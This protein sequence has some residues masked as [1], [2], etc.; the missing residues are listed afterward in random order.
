[1]NTEN[2]FPR[3][4]GILMHPTSLPGRFGVGDFGEEAYR[5]I[6]FL[7]DA[8][9]KLW[10]V[11]PL[12]PTGYGDSP[13]QS[14]SASAGNP[15]LISIERLIAS[16]EL[17]EGDL[18]EVPVFDED[19]VDFGAVIKFKE[20][21]LRK[22]A[23]R[24][25]RSDRRDEFDEF[26]RENAKWLDEFALFMALKEAHDLVAWSQ[27]PASLA[28]RDARALADWSRKLSQE[29]ETIKYWQFVF[30]RQWHELRE[31]GRQKGIRVIGD[32]PIYVAHDSANVWANRELF[33]L[34]ER[35]NP[36]KVAGVPPDYFSETGQLW[37]NPI[38]N[39]PLMKE[40]GYAWWVERLR[41][42]LRLYDYVRIDHF[43][44]FEAY[45]EVAASEKTAMNGRWVKGP[46][47]EL[48]EVLQRELGDLPII[49]ENLGVITPEVEEIRHRFRMP[50]MAIL[51]FGFGNDPQAPTF[52]PHNYVRE[53]VAYTGT[54]DNDTVVGWWNSRPG[55]G[56]I[57][58]E[59][60]IRKE[61]A[62][63][64]AYLGFKD[65]PV[66]WVLIKGVLASVANTAIV[67]MQDLL[68]LGNE[69]RMNLPGTSSGNWRWRMKPGA[70]TKELAIR[71]RELVTLYER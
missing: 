59:E 66:N 60:D 4:S 48:F 36:E 1:M 42:A 64:R 55:K 54:H 13:F 61:H 10:Q 51:Q 34:D 26:C 41:S 58:T 46:G 33:C 56:S 9:Q 18:G 71:L 22:A 27:W 45:W 37:G 50:G 35:G 52:R 43:R 25:L 21:L 70:L 19:E 3:S 53:L 40:R 8:G 65:E 63:A 29:I 16:G 32:I 69:A 39:W 17:R 11:L 7:A 62:Y 38:Y 31:Y 15:L 24:F 67:P 44:G 49:A 30:F 47:A 2:K 12:N 28:G 57:R 14:L 6:D 68:G 5:F 23:E 20:P